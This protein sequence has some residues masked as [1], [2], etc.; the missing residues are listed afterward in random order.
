MD[1]YYFGDIKDNKGNDM[2]IEAVIICYNYSDYLE[3]TLPRNIDILDRIVVVTHPSDKKTIQLCNKYSVDCVK[4]TV[5]HDDGDAFNKGR[6]INLGLSHLRHSGWLLHLDADI[7]LPHRFRYMLH[8]AKLNKQKIY[9]CDR[10]S[11]ISYEN[12]MEN[13]HKIV[14]QFSWRY[15]VSPEYNFSV[16]SRVVHKEYGWCPLGFFQL[17]HSYMR[18]TYPIICGSAEHS[19]ILFS[20][21]WPR[22][23]RLLLP[24]FFVYHLESEK[25]KMGANWH[26]R[27]TKMFGSDEEAPIRFELAKDQKMMD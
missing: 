8:S 9:G 6:A 14:P 24:E 27:T 18:R 13:K 16:S 5:F 12:W 26:G 1:S 4:T 25:L 23:D 22:E 3:H 21:Q 19:D 10:L 11:T 17:W 7:V 20:V 15:L 2:I